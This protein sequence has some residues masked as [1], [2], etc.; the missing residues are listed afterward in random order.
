[1]TKEILPPYSN[2]TM[3]TSMFGHRQLSH[4]FRV[5]WLV[6][7]HT[8]MDLTTGLST[9]S[10]ID[11]LMRDHEAEVSYGYTPIRPS[12]LT[13]GTSTTLRQPGWMEQFKDKKYPLI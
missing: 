3:K 7:S 9:R 12:V 5:I 8:T 11:V 2:D 1:M 4:I 6:M 10:L 13:R